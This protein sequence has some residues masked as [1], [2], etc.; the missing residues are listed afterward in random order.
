MRRPIRVSTWN[1]L[2]M[3]RKTTS[4]IM[5]SRRD[6]PSGTRPSSRP[7]CTRSGRTATRKEKDLGQRRIAWHQYERRALL[8]QVSEIEQIVLLPKRIIDVVGIHARFRAEEKHNG[9]RPDGVR[10]VLAPRR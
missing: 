8:I 3:P 10:D 5:P 9:F 4:S 2:Y 6:P 1:W 7:I